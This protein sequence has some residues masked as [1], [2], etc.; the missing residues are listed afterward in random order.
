MVNLRILLGFAFLP[1]GLKKVLDEPF[2]DPHNTGAF[3][4]FLH[5]F[6][7][8]GF[9]YQF[10]GAVQLCIAT[11]LLTQTLPTLGAAMAVPLF[12]AIAVFCWSTKAIF[13]AFV[14]T[15]MLAGAAALVVWDFDRW[16]DV[17]GAPPRTPR[18]PAEPPID[19]GLWR[20]CGAAILILYLGI[21]AMS[22]GVY[23][24]RG[25]ELD[26]PAFWMLPLIAMLPIVTLVI[27][28]LRR[29]SA[30]KH[31]TEVP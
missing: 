27:E 3:H 7:A 20:R 10:V 26:N 15:L 17:V 4:D 31:Q 28:Q 29:R 23:R 24:P 2:T 12:A 22:G 18:E 11:L 13:T 1:A 8:T 19:L 21:T 9:F 5:A 14:V 25:V 6:H 30:R 16:R